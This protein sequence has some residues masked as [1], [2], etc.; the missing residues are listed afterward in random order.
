MSNKIRV[1]CEQC[2]KETNHEV[3]AAQTTKSSPEDEYNWCTDYQI[4]RCCG[5]DTISFR[6]ET[7]N[8]DDYDPETGELIPTIKLY[9]HRMARRRSLENYY[10]LPPTIGRIYREILSAMNNSSVIL[11]AIGLR[12]L[13]EGVCTDQK[14]KG[15]TLENMIDSL[16]SEGVLSTNQAK[17]LHAHRFL[18]NVAAHEIMPAKPHELVAALDIA[19]TLLK[20]IYILPKI[21]DEITTGKKK[22]H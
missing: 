12:A 17:I 16:S 10:Y 2:C 18:G 4:V 19:E 1:L 14:V 3:L 8:E 21:A 15:S 7:L 22:S 6:E 11:A 20:T 5:C 9:P 13:I